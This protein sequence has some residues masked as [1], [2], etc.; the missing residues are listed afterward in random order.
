[1]AF[2]ADDLDCEHARCTAAG[3]APEKTV[4]FERDCTL[5]ARFFLLPDPDGYRIEDLQRHGR[6]R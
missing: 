1:M 6:Y 5:V 3:L 2:C 4:A